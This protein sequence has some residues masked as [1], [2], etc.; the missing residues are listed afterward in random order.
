MS[1]PFPQLPLFFAVKVTDE[2]DADADTGKLV[3]AS[4]AAATLVATFAAESPTA[5]FTGHDCPE[6]IRRKTPF[7]FIVGVTSVPATVNVSVPV[8]AAEELLSATGSAQSSLV[9]VFLRNALIIKDS[10]EPAPK[11]ASACSSL[12][13]SVREPFSLIFVRSG[14]PTIKFFQGIG[15][16][17]AVI[18]PPN[19]VAKIG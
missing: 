10:C 19:S 16:V 12:V 14:W 13:I 5:T 3:F 6:I 7:S 2:V 15:P 8:A 11:R 18:E 9:L 4:M 17:L 1:R